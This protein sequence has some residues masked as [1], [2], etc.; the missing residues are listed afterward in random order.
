M[1]PEN[2][3]D[4]YMTNKTDGLNHLFYYKFLYS[5]YPAIASCSS[6]LFLSY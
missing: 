6:Y 4:E 2:C 1:N 5:K 3:D